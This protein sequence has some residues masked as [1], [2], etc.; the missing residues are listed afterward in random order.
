[1]DGEVK[2]EGEGAL[3]L[4]PIPPFT[5]RTDPP[6]PPQARPCGSLGP[7]SWGLSLSF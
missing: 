7:S 3:R 1:M 4:G 6:P 5:G 2:E